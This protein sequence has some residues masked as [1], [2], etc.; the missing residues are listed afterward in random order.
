MCKNAWWSPNVCAPNIHVQKHLV[1]P[2][3]FYAQ[4][5]CARVFWDSHFSLIQKAFGDNQ[6]LEYGNGGEEMVNDVVGDNV[7]VLC[8]SSIDEIFRIML[9]DILI[10]M[11]KEHFTNAWG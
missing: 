1:T 2:K 6:T 3:S 5:N 4:C 10:H 8:Q 7:T 11:V 9:V